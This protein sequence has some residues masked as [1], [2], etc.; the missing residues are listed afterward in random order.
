MKTNL[1]ASFTLPI[2]DE[3]NRTHR[4]HDALPAMPDDLSR[5]VP[6]STPRRIAAAF[7]TATIQEHLNRRLEGK[8]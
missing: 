2:L 1:Y 6:A 8:S 3:L 5:R 7:M 4:D